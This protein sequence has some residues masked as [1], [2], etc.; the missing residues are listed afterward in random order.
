M[1][2]SAMYSPV[3]HARTPQLGHSLW[4]ED[5]TFALA[6]RDSF[7][8]WAPVDG[9]ILHVLHETIQPSLYPAY[10]AVDHPLANRRHIEHQ[11][12]QDDSNPLFR[13]PRQQAQED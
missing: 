4:E 11:E 7:R 1:N 12:H 10:M 5:Q 9:S 8:H 3:I 6:L 2:T 13:W